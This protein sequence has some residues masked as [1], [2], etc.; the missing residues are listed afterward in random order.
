MRASSAECLYFL[1]YS[2][3]FLS[4]LSIILFIFFIATAVADY[5]KNRIKRKPFTFE[6][7]EGV[8]WRLSNFF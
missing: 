8:F 3:Y 5:S 6:G 2:I 1:S 7:E 4:S